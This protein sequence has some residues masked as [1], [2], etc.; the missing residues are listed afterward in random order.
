MP[1]YFALL[2]ERARRG[3]RTDSHH[4]LCVVA[5][6]FVV[7]V[8]PFDPGFAPAILHTANETEDEKTPV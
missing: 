8:G 7:L 2:V 6:V 1:F 3:N 5:Q 4:D